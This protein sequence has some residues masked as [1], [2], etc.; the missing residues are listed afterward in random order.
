[1]F[2][3][4][5]KITK[6]KILATLL[7]S[8]FV[9]TIFYIVIKE[10][11]KVSTKKEQETEEIIFDKPQ[12]EYRSIFPEITSDFIQEIIEKD[13]SGKVIFDE[14]LINKIFKSIFIRLNVFVG[15]IE[16]DYEI[17]EEDNKIVLYFKHVNGEE[18]LETKS[19][20]IIL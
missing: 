10:V 20:E 8:V 18:I 6:S 13:E 11:T 9:G 14:K 12:K 2:Q 19:Y 4:K 7:L 16:F 17:F 3:I 1:M 15:N 5:K